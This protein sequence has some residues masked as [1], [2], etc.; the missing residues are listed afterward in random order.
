MFRGKELKREGRVALGGLVLLAILSFFISSPD[1]RLHVYFLD[2]GQGDAIF[3]QTP[4]GRQ[5]LIDGGPDRAILRRLGG[6]MPFYD[7]TIDLVVATH[8]DADHLA[9]LVEVLKKYKVENIFETGMACETTLCAE[10]ERAK[11]A[12]KGWV[13]YANLGEE[14]ALEDGVRLIIL[15]PFEELRGQKLSAR[16]NG[17]VVAKLVYGPQSLLLTGD[18]EAMVEN[19]LVLAQINLKADFLK[20]AHHGSK[21]STTEEFLKVVTPKAAFIE[22]GRNNRYGHPTAE[23]LNRL[24]KFQIPYYRTDTDGTIELVLDGEDYR[25]RKK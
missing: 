19:K 2:V 20:I 15:Y 7:R 12:E 1:G 9:G 16:N 18:I 11:L 24:E 4:G 25:I 8:P 10:W 14:M 23:V 5:L 21:T 17:G 6:V 22:V 3:I 13:N